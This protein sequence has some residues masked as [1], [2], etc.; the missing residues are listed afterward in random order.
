LTNCLRMFCNFATQSMDTVWVCGKCISTKDEIINN[1]IGP[2]TCLDEE[3]HARE[4]SYHQ[5]KGLPR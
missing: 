3:L 1:I 2:N 5:R 4:D